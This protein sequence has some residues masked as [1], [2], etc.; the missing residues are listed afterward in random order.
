MVRTMRSDD[1]PC[2]TPLRPPAVPVWACMLLAGVLLGGCGDDG[3]RTPVLR[4]ERTTV[5]MVVAERMTASQAVV[6]FNDG[7]GTLEIT[8]L[9]VTFPWVTVDPQALTI[10]P[11]GQGSA[12]LVA[13]ASSVTAGDYAGRITIESN[14]PDHS[15]LIVELLVTV[16]EGYPPSLTLSPLSFT[17]ALEPGESTH[18][19]CAAVNAGPE[20]GRITD[21]SVGCGWVA[22]TPTSLDLPPGARA[23]ITLAVRTTGLAEGRHQ[24]TVSAHT[25]DVN[26]PRWDV[27]I[28]LTV[29]VGAGVPRLVIAE[30][31][32]GTW[33]PYCP[34]AMN[35]LHALHNQVGPERMGVVA[36]HLQD[37]FALIAG[38]DRAVLYGVSGIPDVWF[39]GTVHRVGGTT[40]SPVSYTSEYNQRASVPAPVSLW[41]ML[42]EY[43][44][45]TGS[46]TVEARCRNV[47]SQTIDARLVV[48][49]TGVDTAYTWLTM[50]HLY[51]TAISF[52]AGST[53]TP[54]FLAP[55]QSET[56][57]TAFSTPAAWGERERELVAFVQSPA[58]KEI[59]QGAVIRLP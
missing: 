34:G 7:D 16:I 37:P 9:T 53:G 15:L 5:S 58:T 50:N 43:D 45:A 25:T 27:A 56:V 39:D 55:G 49:M 6:F 35:G 47:G 14:D 46:G 4:L 10:P 11:H 52:P 32:T 24:C 22:A 23:D 13:T 20:T 41:L 18:V 17:L 57:A 8:G 54:L 12:T 36:S 21:V 3:P 40:S 30:E 42:A 38:Q 1:A 59:H 33:C 51:N 26:A 31:F 19:T 44:V 29:G 48:V 28:D 2:V